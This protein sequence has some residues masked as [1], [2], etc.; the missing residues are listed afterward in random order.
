MRNWLKGLVLACPFGE[1]T[2]ACPAA[3]MRLLPLRERLVAVDAM[4]PDTIEQV[5]LSH[6]SCLCRR[7]GQKGYSC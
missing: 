2:E 6:E 5:L 1:E 3:E 7:T 4:S